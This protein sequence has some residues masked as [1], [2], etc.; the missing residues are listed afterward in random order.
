MPFTLLQNYIEKLISAGLGLVFL[1]LQNLQLAKTALQY[2][3]RAR[4][5]DVAGPEVVSLKGVTR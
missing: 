1:L 2:S 5:N 3:N 4:N